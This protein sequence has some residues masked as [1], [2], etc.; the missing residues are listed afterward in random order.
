[1][2]TYSK[3]KKADELRLLLHKK[4]DN[5]YDVL[6]VYRAWLDTNKINAEDECGYP[7]EQ[8]YDIENINAFV[9]EMLL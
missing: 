4:L 8:A 2:Q 1:M 3:L 6:S 9:K 7:S 5:N